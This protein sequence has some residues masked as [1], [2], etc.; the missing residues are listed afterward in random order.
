MRV[1]GGGGR[2]VQEGL[3][4]RGVSTVCLLMFSILYAGI[5]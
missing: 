3:V 2:E 1:T 5:R 4:G